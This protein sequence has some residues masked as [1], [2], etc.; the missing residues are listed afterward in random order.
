[1]SLVGISFLFLDL[2]PPHCSPPSS[3]RQ[4]RALQ[5]GSQRPPGP[6]C[7]RTPDHSQWVRTGSS[8]VS[9]WD[10]CVLTLTGSYGQT[11]NMEILSL[12]STCH[13]SPGLGLCSLG[14]EKQA[15]GSHWPP[16][17]QSGGAPG[18]THTDRGQVWGHQPRGTPATLLPV[19]QSPF[20]LHTSTAFHF[21]L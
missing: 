3:D 14:G 9:Q 13:F 1:M 2:A 8:R 11:V 21:Q 15:Q 6:C 16:A 17:S 5:P 19:W 7:P 4:R 18:R 12:S 10:I 20:L